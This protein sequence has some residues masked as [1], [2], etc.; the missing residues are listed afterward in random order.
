MP[1]GKRHSKKFDRCVSDVKRSGSAADPYAVCI[2]TVKNPKRKRKRPMPAGLKRYWAKKRKAK[3]HRR[4]ARQNPKGFVILAFGHGKRGYY[5]GGRAF[6]P[7]I[8]R[9]HVFASR[10]EAD[11]KV[12]A[13]KPMLPRGWDLAVGPMPG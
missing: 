10:G 11:T 4:R 1:G 13:L 2:K 12:R 7:K 8:T 3:N 5:D 9:A 6:N